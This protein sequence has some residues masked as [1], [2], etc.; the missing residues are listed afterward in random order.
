MPSVGSAVSLSCEW[1]NAKYAKVRDVRG[2]LLCP[3][4]S[5]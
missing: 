3:L 4:Y 5:L 1:L 2:R